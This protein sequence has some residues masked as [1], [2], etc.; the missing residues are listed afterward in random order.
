MNLQE[1]KN[2]QPE[3]RPIESAELLKEEKGRGVVRPKAK[4]GRPSSK[5]VGV[6]YKRVWYD[7]PA[8]LIKEAKAFEVLNDYSTK[9]ELAE[10]AIRA[11]IK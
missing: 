11:F 10:A 5:K 7:L 9:S 3:D 1:L 8:D 6:E 4:L 2:N